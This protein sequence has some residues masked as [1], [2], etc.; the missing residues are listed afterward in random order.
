MTDVLTVGETMASMRAVAP[1][2][3]GGAM[4]LSVAGAESNVAIGLARLGHRVSWVGVVGADEL[5][6]LVL[7]TLRAEGVTLEAVR[8]DADRQT[9]VMV[10]ERRISDL[11][12][13]IYHRSGSAGSTVSAEDVTAG[14]RPPPSWVHLTG[15]T[16]ALGDRARGAVDAAVAQARRTGIPISLDVNFRRR[17]WTESAAGEC[18]RR[19]APHARLLVASEDELHLAAPAD[20]R[21]EEDR[22]A[23]LLAA[24]VAEVVI[25]RGARGAS[26]YGAD[27]RVD[28]PAHRVRVA[29]TI[30]AGDAF[31]AGLLSA[32]LENLSVPDRLERAA[33]CGAFAVAST[34]DWEGLPTRAELSLL[35][36]E[37]GTTQR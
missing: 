18:L 17:L 10:V 1:L 36:L 19:L 23:A 12:G 5:G 11:S 8:V 30:G 14:F 9:G 2:R 20:A 34:G 21:N 15:I 4:S 6:A 35:D 16:P 24:G 22:V 37:A 33:T 7:R 27:G 3:L 26:L 13:V 29:D 32:T 25:K 28:R 31:V